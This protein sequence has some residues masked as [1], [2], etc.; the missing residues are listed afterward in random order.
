MSGKLVPY[1]AS[2]KLESFLLSNCG[3]YF[4]CDT[5]TCMTDLQALKEWKIKHGEER[6]DT[7]IPVYPYASDS[8][9][10]E[11]ADYAYQAWH[12]RLHAEGEYEFDMAGEIKLAAYQMALAHHA[13]LPDSDCWALFFHVYARVLYHYYH[14]GMD[15]PHRAEFI[16]ACFVYGCRNAALGCYLD[17]YNDYPAQEH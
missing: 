16:T 6:F 1:R 9:F 3:P 17:Q 7:P 2:E 15:P 4:V 11:Q 14:D 12:D 10:S 5:G 8:P 13:G